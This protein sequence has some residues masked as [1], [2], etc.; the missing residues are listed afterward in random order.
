M[1]DAN[2]FALMDNFIHLKDFSLHLVSLKKTSSVLHKSSANITL[3]TF[4]QRASKHMEPGKVSAVE[5]GPKSQLNVCNVR[6]IAH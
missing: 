5:H 1:R 6:R 3:Y 4:S 2:M